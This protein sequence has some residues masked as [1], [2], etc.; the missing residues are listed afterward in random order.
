MALFKLNASLFGI[1]GREFLVQSF[2]TSAATSALALS[3]FRFGLGLVAF[4][5]AAQL[6][7]HDSSPLKLPNWAQALEQQHA[8]AVFPRPAIPQFLCQC[9]SFAAAIGIPVSASEIV[10]QL[11]HALIDCFLRIRCGWRDVT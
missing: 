8:E 10:L 3:Q 5:A 4:D 9:G 2:L 1:V 6:F 7:D 11:P